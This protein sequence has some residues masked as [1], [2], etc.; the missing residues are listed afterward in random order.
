MLA[1]TDRQIGSEDANNVDCEA[2]ILVRAEKVSFESLTFA[3]GA[4]VRALSI[5]QSR[6][7]QAFCPGK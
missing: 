6:D 1:D 5:R 4:N 7:W 3:G 2:W